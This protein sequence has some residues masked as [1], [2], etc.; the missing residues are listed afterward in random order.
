M[1]HRSTLGSKKSKPI[2]SVKVMTL[3][4]VTTLSHT[5]IIVWGKG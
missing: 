2:L 4:L 1:A 3:T 5:I